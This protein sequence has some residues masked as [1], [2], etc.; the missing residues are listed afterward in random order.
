M[1]TLARER[2]VLK[3][4]L[5]DRQK[6]SWWRAYHTVSRH[7]PRCGQGLRFGHVSAE[8]TRRFLCGGCGYIFYHNPKLVAAT[9]PQRDGRIYLLRR[10]IEPGRGLWTYPAGYMELGETVEEA[11]LRETREEL[12]CRVRLVSGPRL[13]SYADAGVVTVTYH[14]RVM[15]GEEPRPGD[16][17]I[18]VQSFTPETLPWE[19][20]A[21]R[22]TLHGLKD[23]AEDVLAERFA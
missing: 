2:R 1:L 22:S 16:E 17:A 19:E 3:R 12:L 20:L 13:Y 8:K 11:A 10:N 18:E 6:G 4:I 7:C 14:A 23:W 9:L 21:F 15:A 5:G